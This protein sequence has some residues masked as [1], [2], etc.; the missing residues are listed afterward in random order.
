MGEKKNWNCSYVKFMDAEMCETEELS[1]ILT[2]IMTF[3]SQRVAQ[4]ARLHFSNLYRSWSEIF[5]SGI[6]SLAF[7]LFLSGSQGIVAGEWPTPLQTPVL[8]MKKGRMLLWNLSLSLFKTCLRN[9]RS[10]DNIVPSKVGAA[11][12]INISLH[13]LMDKNVFVHGIWE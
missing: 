13:S 5:C 1:I 2:L 3:G 8:S 9:R 11:A 10:R 6:L 12:S 7:P 4:T